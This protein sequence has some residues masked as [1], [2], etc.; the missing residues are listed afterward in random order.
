MGH[1]PVTEV[2]E[3]EPPQMPEVV[4]RELW[5]NIKGGYVLLVA[6]V[7]MWSLAS[8][9]L[10]DGTLALIVNILFLF[11]SVVWGLT[12]VRMTGLIWP[13]L[14][15]RIVLTVLVGGTIIV[16][17]AIFLTLLERVV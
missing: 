6:I 3:D 12:L 17:R 13:G 2:R 16:F 14:R 15:L 11:I 10:S 8:H 1:K 9:F 7:G 4:A 5:R